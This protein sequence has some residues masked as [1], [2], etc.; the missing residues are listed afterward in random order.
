MNKDTPIV[1]VAVDE[2]GAEFLYNHKPVRR[3]GYWK[4]DDNFNAPHYLWVPLGTIEMLLGKSLS[5]KDEAVLL[6]AK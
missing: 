6:G 2:S 5:W 4:C 3:I 1:W